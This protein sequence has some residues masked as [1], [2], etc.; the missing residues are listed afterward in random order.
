MTDTVVLK[1]PTEIDAETAP[2]TLSANAAKRI[3]EIMASEPDAKSMLRIA[4]SGG[5]CSGFQYGFTFDDVQNDDD[6]VVSRDGATLLVDAVSLNYMSG[7][8][9]DFVEDLAG[10]AFQIKN[11][12]ATS[13]CGCGSSFAV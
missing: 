13:K 2:V 4:V 6:L 5:G 3:K 12:N 1:R 9:L 7:S 8:E 10:A 11:P